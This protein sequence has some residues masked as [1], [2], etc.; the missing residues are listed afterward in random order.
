[1]LGSAVVAMAAVFGGGGQDIAQRAIRARGMMWNGGTECAIKAGIALASRY[2]A[3][4]SGLYAGRGVFH[5]GNPPR[6][7][8]GAVRK[9]ARSKPRLHVFGTIGDT[10]GADANKR[11]PFAGHAPPFQ[12]AK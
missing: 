2:P 9:G 8:G 11:G 1:M 10:L 5:L 7:F 12:A 3:P 6:E 4:R